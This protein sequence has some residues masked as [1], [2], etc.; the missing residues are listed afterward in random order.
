MLLRQPLPHRLEAGL[1]RR[2]DDALDEHDA[3]VDLLELMHQVHDLGIGTTRQ[4]VGAVR[5]VAV[6]ALAVEAPR[7]PA[8][9]GRLFGHRVP[10]AGAAVVVVVDS[11]HRLGQP[12]HHELAPGIDLLVPRFGVDGASG[13]PVLGEV[14]QLSLLLLPIG[15]S[16][17]SRIHCTKCS[18]LALPLLKLP[19]LLLEP[20][21]NLPYTTCPCGGRV[22]LPIS[23]LRLHLRLFHERLGGCPGRAT[24]HASSTGLLA[25]SRK[26]YQHPCPP[27]RQP[28][29]FL[30]SELV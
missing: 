23:R 1:G 24:P 10:A 15:R 26:Q 6:P 30:F 4:A 21:H 28:L 22:H 13:E 27:P 14:V 8:A 29:G 16:G 20:P 2:V 3:V 17:R 12:L 5:A 18:P 25:A 19:L 9:R 11:R 7:T